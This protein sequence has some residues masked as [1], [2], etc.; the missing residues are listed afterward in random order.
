[1]FSRLSDLEDS[2]FPAFHPVFEKSVKIPFSSHGHESPLARM[3]IPF[4]IWRNLSNDRTESDS[5]RNA[6]RILLVDFLTDE[7][8]GPEV[9]PKYLYSRCIFNS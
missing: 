9:L 7:I 2:E 5:T 4:N 6:H 8:N 1:M 3:D